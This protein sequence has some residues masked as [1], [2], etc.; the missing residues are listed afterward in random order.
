[1]GNDLTDGERM[2]RLETELGT[3]KEVV[4]E[5]KKMLTDQGEKYILRVQMDE[6]MRL[7]DQRQKEADAKTESNNLKVEQKIEA[8][9]VEQK[10]DRAAVIVKFEKLEADKKTSRRMLPDIIM[11]ISAVS[12]FILTI[13]IALH[14]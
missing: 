3:V 13:Y 10:A 4:F 8:L 5:L 6:I 9:S 7:R 1:M 2:V 12:T 14:K 11:A